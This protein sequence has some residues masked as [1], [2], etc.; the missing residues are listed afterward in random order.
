M[1]T[2]CHGHL[3]GH[4]QDAL[5]LRTGVDVGIVCLVIVLIL[6]SEIHAARQFTNH[7][8]VSATQ[9]FVLQRRLM[10]QTFKGGY[11]T[12]VGEQSQF[13]AHSQES[14]LRTYL[15]RGIIIEAQVAYSSKEYCI[16]PHTHLMGAVGIR[17]ATDVDGMGTTDGLLVFK[18]VSALRCN[19][20]Q[21]SH[22]LFHNLRAD[23]IALENRNLQFHIL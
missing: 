6:L 12:D 15:Q 22:T 18:L 17:F 20:I 21:H 9:Q 8:E 19:G 3:E 11:R 14:R 23:T 7:H 4:L 2:T 13:L 10:Q 5:Y 16:S 1:L